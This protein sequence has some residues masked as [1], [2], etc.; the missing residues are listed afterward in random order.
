MKEKVMCQLDATFKSIHKELLRATNLTL[1][2]WLGCRRLKS[3]GQDNA[4]G[5]QKVKN[6]Q[7]R[8]EF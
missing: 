6:A 3:L 8:Q 7:D 4:V 1:A 5:I 2:R